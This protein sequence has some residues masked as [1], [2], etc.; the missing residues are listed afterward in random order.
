M[1]RTRVGAR[2][3]YHD[4]SS[5]SSLSAYSASAPLRAGG[6]PPRASVG[7]W[8]PPVR[9][10]LRRRAPAAPSQGTPA[11]LHDLEQRAALAY[12]ALGAL[13]GL[14]RH[15]DARS[16]RRAFRSSSGSAQTLRPAS[17]RS[18]KGQEAMRAAPAHQGSE[19]GI[20][21]AVVEHRAVRQ[22]SERVCGGREE[23][24]RSLP[25]QPSRR[26][27]PSHTTAMHR[28]PFRFGSN[29][30]SSPSK[31]SRRAG[32]GAVG[33]RRERAVTTRR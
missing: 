5:Q 28:Q 13:N 2:R 11:A 30:Q 21:L 26:T 33:E 31:G 12:N 24:V 7:S 19:V 14:A 15:A 22:L 17:A 23:R 8:R 1:D 32:R 29:S 10:H 16:A 4:R 6:G 9:R 20:A 3:T 18:V 25:R 27:R